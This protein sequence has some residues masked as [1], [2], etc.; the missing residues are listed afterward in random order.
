MEKLLPV[1][2]GK[3]MLLLDTCGVLDLFFLNSLGF[4]VFK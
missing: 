2:A 3:I 4:F 1:V